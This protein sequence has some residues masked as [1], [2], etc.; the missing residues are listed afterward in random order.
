M[1]AAAEIPV[2]LRRLSF[3]A[4]LAVTAC[5][6]SPLTDRD[7][8]VEVHDKGQWAVSE[9]QA[10]E[11]KLALLDYL[12]TAHPTQNSMDQLAERERPSIHAKIATYY[13]QYYGGL[14][15]TKSGWD[16]AGEKQIL[17]NGLCEM[18]P[19]PFGSEGMRKELI[20]VN[21]GGGCFF[22]ALYNPAQHKITVFTVNGHA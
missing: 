6:Q 20:G 22:R 16:D 14:Y 4:V 3:L 11:A 15:G 17:I 19:P 2:I 1:K 18:L 7:F 8:I 9:A 10:A 13:L 5:S 21:D 12:A